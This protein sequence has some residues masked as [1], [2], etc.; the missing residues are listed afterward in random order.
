MKF[1]TFLTLVFLGFGAGILAYDHVPQVSAFFG[2][3]SE[4][5]AAKPARSARS[6]KTARSAKAAPSAEKPTASRARKSIDIPSEIPGSY[7]GNSLAGK[8]W[9]DTEALAEKLAAGILS[10]LNGTDN[11][12]VQAFIAE[13]ANRLM[14]AQW[15]LAT[16]ENAVSAEATQKALDSVRRDLTKHRERLEKLRR[17]ASEAT[18]SR[19]DS[20][21]FRMRREEDS[22]RIRESELASPLSMKEALESTPGAA[23]LVEQVT[24]NLDWMEQ[25][26][27]SGEC[28]NPG[29]AMGILAAIAGD[30]EQL[31]YKKMQRDIATATAVEWAKSGWLFEKAL[32]RANYYIESWEEDRLHTEFDTIPFWMRRMTCGSKGDNNFGSVESLRWLRD[33][34]NLPTERYSGAC[35]QA[36]YLTYNIFG[37]SIHGPWYYEPFQEEHGDNIAQSV[38]EVGGVCGSL[39]HFGAFAAIANGIPGMTF[40]EPGHCAYLYLNKGKWQPSYSM[41]W[42]KGL[43]WQVWSRIHKFAS[44][45]MATELFSNEQAEQTQLSN[46]F[47]SLGKLFAAAGDSQKATDCFSAAV[48]EQPRNYG[49]WVDYAVFLRQALP[50]DATAWKQ[51]NSSACS[52]LAPLFPEM[53][54]ELMKTHVYPGL[55][56]CGLPAGEAMKCLAAFWKPLEAMGPDRWGIEELCNAQ[57][58]LLKQL[59][60]PMP[61]GTLALYKQ[62]LGLCA[63]KAAYAPV[64]LSW[65]NSSAA[66]MSPEMQQKFTKATLAGLSKSDEM[67]ADA[68]DRMLSQAIAGA[69]RM[70]DLNAFQTIGKMLSEKYKSGTPP[71][72]EPFPGKLASRGGMIYTSSSDYDDPAAHW[73]VL[74]PTGG[75]FHTRNEENPWVVVEMP[76]TV[77]VTGVVTIFTG[78]QNNVRNHDM[79]VQYS[80]TGND[81]DWHEAGAFP[82]PST[83]V[84][85]RLNLRES[86]PRARFIRII[87]GGKKDFFHLHCI[88]VYGE[89]AS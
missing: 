1:G 9:A 33:N 89:Q 82:E 81:N 73:G 35:W 11:A 19:A 34:V 5:S 78:G 72:W 79:R 58:N 65:G 16:A 8:D 57:V 27:Y 63:G 52:L 23:N 77:Y 37:D 47:W 22:I 87:R 46:A 7:I 30:D 13:P 74:E 62:V 28:L 80:E 20:L 54:A 85:N 53:A 70:R 51:L 75:R 31:A 60:A 61:E 86:K 88:Y 25:F 10:T 3:E 69:E 43:H 14:L 42:Q 29:R 56:D 6:N 39:S 24:N 66:G 84:I 21:Q 38:Y 59:G 64:I 17:E 36:S 4:P 45:H 49:A 83:R 76:R 71:Q 41:S 40:G 44:L 15:R 55:V 26:V 50:Q 68:R 2:A 32:I 18:G 48:K 67:N 12:S